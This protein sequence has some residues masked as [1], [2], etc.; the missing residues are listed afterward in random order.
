MYQLRI[1]GKTGNIYVSGSAENVVTGIKANKD[2]S[3]KIKG[4]TGS[5]WANNAKG[6]VTG[7]H[8]A[9]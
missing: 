4:N 9:N 1:D 3:A 7:I 8:V 2:T 5:V 6:V